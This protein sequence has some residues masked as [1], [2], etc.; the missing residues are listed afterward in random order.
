LHYL[1]ARYIKK[2][3]NWTGLMRTKLKILDRQGKCW[4]G[5]CCC[6]DDLPARTFGARYTQHLHV[7]LTW[8]P[9]SG[10]FSLCYRTCC[11]RCLYLELPHL[12]ITM[13]HHTPILPLHPPETFPG[14]TPT[15]P[16]YKSKMTRLYCD[17]S[18][19]SL[20][21]NRS[22]QSWGALLLCSHSINTVM[23]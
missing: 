21:R 10:A 4:S 2:M 17:L 14:F 19:G 6:E 18:R 5:I 1:G 15:P 13:D 3:H 23:V 7:G 8:L 22:L 16:S 12:L 11:A 20:H 9:S